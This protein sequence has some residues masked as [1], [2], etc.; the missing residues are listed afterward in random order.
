MSLMASE[1]P[2]LT[3]DD[4]PVRTFTFDDVLRM[5]E[6]GILRDTDRVELVDG[7]LITMSPEGIDHRELTA[8]LNR[9]A[10]GAYADDAHQVYIQSTHRMGDRHF[11]QPDVLV[12]RRTGTWQGPD[13]VVLV[14]EVARTSLRYDLR[15]KAADY[16]AWGVEEYWVVDIAGERVV[17]HRD[18]DPAGGYGDVRTVPRNGTVSFPRSD[19]V[20]GVADLFT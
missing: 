4:R 3:F 20:L 13:E 12:A 2:S 5:S 15:A 17:R 1:A 7:V 6:V 19:A 18:P 9:I 16:A 11:R 8:T 14:I 10:I